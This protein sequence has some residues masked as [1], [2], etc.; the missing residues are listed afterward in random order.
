LLHVQVS[1]LY[2]PLSHSSHNSGWINASPQTPL[3]LYDIV[4]V[5]LESLSLKITLQD[6]VSHSCHATHCNFKI[7]EARSQCTLLSQSTLEDIVSQLQADAQNSDTKSIISGVSEI[8]RL[9]ANSI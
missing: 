3:S 1:L 9:F 5:I 8:E 6:P 7:Q 2:S 4:P